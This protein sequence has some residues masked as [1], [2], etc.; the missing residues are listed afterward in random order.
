VPEKLAKEFGQAE[1]GQTFEIKK[2]A[3]AAP[4]TPQEKQIRLEIGEM[5]GAKIL[6]RKKEELVMLTGNPVIDTFRKLNQY[7]V[8]SSKIKIRDKATVFRLLA[9]MLNAGLPLIK[10][11]NTLGVQQQKNAKLAGILFDLAHKIEGGKSLSEAMG[12]HSDVFDDSQI[13]VIKAGEASGQL[14]KTLR[15]LAEEIEKSASVQGKIKGALIYPAVIMSLLFA[16]IFLMMIMVV[17]QMST[18]FT[19]S[20]KAL[21]L[22]TQ[23]LI[24]LSDFSVK[25]WPVVIIGIAGIFFGVGAWKKTRTGKY[26]W[27]ALLLKLPIFGP[28]IQKGVLSKFAR[29]FSN[30]MASG[31]PIIKSIEIVAHA[32]GNEVYKRRLL[33]TA[34][35]MKRGIPMA[36]NMSESKLFP[37]ILVNMI[38]VGEQT[39][40]LETVVLKVADFYD[41][42]I[43]EVINSLTKI[44]EP[45][46][47][48]IIGATVGG[49]VAAIMLPIIQL[50][51]VAGV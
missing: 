4:N 43:N 2:E 21:P 26:L 47:L 17:P 13:G 22:P 5:R 10:S 38:E 18:L 7:L 14:N 25:Y 32:V 27:D 45:L 6:L 44:M 49:L 30:M 48:V 40:Q 51:D 35:D 46:I 16:V 20:G 8:S 37:K 41:E 36:E 50:T 15:S 3:E 23:I 11:L 19:Q 39:A 9:V 12:E 42:E 29:S 34:E 24:G 28:V 1:K 31:V 33:L